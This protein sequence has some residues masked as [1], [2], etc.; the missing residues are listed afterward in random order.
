M[1]LGKKPQKLE[2]IALHQMGKDITLIFTVC[3]VFTLGIENGEPG[4]VNNRG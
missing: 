2:L 3:F 1:L 4:K